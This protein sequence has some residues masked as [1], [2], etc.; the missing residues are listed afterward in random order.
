M[1]QR[2]VA[3][4]IV[5]RYSQIDYIKPVTDDFKVM[6]CFESEQQVDNLIKSYHRKGLAAIRLNAIID[7]GGDHAVLFSGKYVIHK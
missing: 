4:H 5:I 6:C 3:T 2:E 1:K 7:Q